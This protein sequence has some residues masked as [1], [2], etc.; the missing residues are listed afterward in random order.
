MGAH[1]EYS[2]DTEDENC[3]E[4]GEKEGVESHD[5]VVQKVAMSTAFKVVVTAA[6]TALMQVAMRQATAFLVKRDEST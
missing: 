4:S 6:L 5:P 3:T 1:C 2:I